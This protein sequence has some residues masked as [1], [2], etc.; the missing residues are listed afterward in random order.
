MTTKGCITLLYFE[1][2]NIY[3]EHKY[4]LF[5]KIQMIYMDE[6]KRKQINEDLHKVEWHVSEL[7]AGLFLDKIVLLLGILYLMLDYSRS[8]DE[9]NYKIRGA[10]KI[11]K[12]C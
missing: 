7:P 8:K 10:W 3:I 6:E 9:K 4:I 12:K 2:S 1:H 11:Y 5:N